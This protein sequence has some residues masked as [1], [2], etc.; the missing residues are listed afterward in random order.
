[1][2]QEFDDAAWMAHRACAGENPDM[3]FPARG[4]STEPAKAVCRTCTVRAACLEYALDNQIH[5][6]VWGG[7]S[8]RSR[9]KILRG[10]RLQVVAA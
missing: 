10:R 6:G 5:H 8:E 4:Y 1:M 2:M 7:E 9:R 3:F